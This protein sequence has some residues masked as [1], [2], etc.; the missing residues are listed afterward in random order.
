MAI[1]S[2]TYTGNG[3][4][5]LFSITFPYIE[6]TDVDVYLNGTLQTI[7]TQ[8]SFANATTVEF[9]AAPSNGA[10]VK[11]D[12]STDDANLQATFFPGSSIKAVDLNENFDQALYIAQETANNVAN[13]VAGLIPDGTI[14]NAKINATAGINATK[15]SFTQAGTGATA[16]TIDSKLK[17]VVSV[18]DFGAVGDGVADDTAAIQ[19][20]INYCAT[21]SRWPTLTLTGRHKITASLIVDRLVDSTITEFRITANGPGAGFY[22]AGNVTL[23]DS[24]IAV[25]TDP[26]SEWITFEGV[27]FESSS[28]FNQAYVL[29]QKFLRCKFLN[30]FFWLF[31]CQK[32]TIYVQTLYFQSCNIRNSPTKFIECAGLYDVVFDSCVIENNFQLVRCV[33]AVRGTN[34]LRIVNS[35]IEGQQETTI[36]ITG[37]AGFV[38]AHNHVESNPANDL[39]FFAGGL[40]NKSISII[41]N[42]VYNPSGA[43]CY[44]GPTDQV[45]SAG[46]Y[47]SGTIHSNAVQITNLTSISDSA[48]TIADATITSK[49][50]GVVR[51]GNAQEDWTHSANHFTKSA[52]GNFG[53]GLTPVSTVRAAFLGSDQ[54]SSNFAVTA[55]DSVGNTIFSARNDRVFM[56]PALNNQV[57]DAAAAAAG[58]PIGGLYRNGSV[59]QVRVT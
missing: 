55:L 11:L 43:L 32:S 28:V 18:K 44:Y 8:Y 1:T 49:V 38:Y 4:N 34:G 9:V 59:V 30:C 16:R 5:K 46:N 48:A 6:S 29:S 15:L 12:R 21:F 17:D 35:V 39:N 10:I 27:A 45:F 42:Y 50:N 40:Q 7:T 54:T 26:K 36:A 20:A 13:A 57:N 56:L 37:A 41:G 51:Y 58:I 47:A 53:F 19:A 2:N 3:S 31:R 52:A 33:D 23:F 24:T 25:T 22:V 14:T